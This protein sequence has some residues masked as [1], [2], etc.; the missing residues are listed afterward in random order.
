MS[1]DDPLYEAGAPIP[2]EPSHT[3]HIYVQIRDEDE[4]GDYVKQFRE[5][6]KDGTARLGLKPLPDEENVETLEI[7]EDAYR[8]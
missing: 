8:K 7:G 2:N 1:P 6:E 3:E 5:V 4:K